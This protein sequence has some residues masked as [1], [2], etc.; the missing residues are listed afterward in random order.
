PR[1]GLQLIEPPWKA[2]LSNKGILPLL[3]DAHQGHPNLLPATF[4]DG[5]ELPRGWVRKPLHSREGANITM[6]LDDGRELR[7]AGPYDGPCIRQACHPLPA[8]HGHH[9]LIG[10]WLVGDRACGI[11]IREDSSL[12][13]QDSARFV[14]HAIVEEARSVLIA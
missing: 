3:W 10:S 1:S 2:L 7:T 6:H 9:P 5:G 12:V 14:P 8:F 13:T 11:G 4:D